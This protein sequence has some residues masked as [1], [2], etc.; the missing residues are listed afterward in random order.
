MEHTWNTVFLPENRPSYASHR[1][2]ISTD[3]GAYAGM[4]K[5]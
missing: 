3:W 2:P 4:R 5:G 1:P